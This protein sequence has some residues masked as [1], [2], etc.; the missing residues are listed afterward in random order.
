MLTFITMSEEFPIKIMDYL[1]IAS[2]TFFGSIMF[3]LIFDYFLFGNLPKEQE[4]SWK[5]III[6]IIIGVCFCSVCT[7]FGL[8][9]SRRG[10]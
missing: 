2:V 8:E 6:M 4:K 7:G 3:T 10:W 9:W 5:I 1:I